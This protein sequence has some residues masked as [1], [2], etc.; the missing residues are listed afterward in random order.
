VRTYLDTDLQALQRKSLIGTFLIAANLLTIFAVSQ[1]I[2]A[3]YDREIQKIYENKTNTA[4]INVSGRYSTHYLL[5]NDESEQIK[6]LTN[7]RS[8]S[9]SIFWLIYSMIL[10]VVGMAWKHKGVRFGGLSLLALAIFKLFFVDLW[11]L[12]TLYRIISSISLGVVLLSISFVY[13][14]NKEALKE[15]I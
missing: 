15:I 2:T 6:S 12:G 1:E 10:L 11:S 9:L 5:N 14:K 8:I 13:Q 7:K 3:S 4:G